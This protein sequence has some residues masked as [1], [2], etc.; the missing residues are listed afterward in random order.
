[1]KKAI[2]LLSAI[3]IA[4]ACTKSNTKEN[5]NNQETTS[6]KTAYLD[7]TSEF[8]TCQEWLYI[9]GWE[10][11]FTVYAYLYHDTTEELDD[12]TDTFLVYYK[13]KHYVAIRSG[14]ERLT[15]HIKSN[16]Q[17]SLP[18]QLGSYRKSGK[19]FNARIPFVYGMTYYFNM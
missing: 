14:D 18:V 12:K 17:H 3:L 13:N 11:Y 6:D 9:N 4:I 1:M 5:K 7:E 19:N 2:I 8:I 15:V 10:Y 16:P